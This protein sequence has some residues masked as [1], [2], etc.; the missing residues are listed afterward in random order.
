MAIAGCVNALNPQ[1]DRPFTLLQKPC[2]KEL[3]T[4]IQ[5]AAK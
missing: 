1:P 2:T 5:A 3:A 4:A